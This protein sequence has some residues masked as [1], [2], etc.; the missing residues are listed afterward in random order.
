MDNTTRYKIN[1]LLDKD[2][3]KQYCQS[4]DD[5]PTELIV[6][7]DDVEHRCKVCIEYDNTKHDIWSWFVYYKDVITNEI[8]LESGSTT[9]DNA[10]GNMLNRISNA[11]PINEIKLIDGSHPRVIS[12]GCANNVCEY[13][14]IHRL[15]KVRPYK[16]CD[17][18]DFKGNAVKVLDLHCCPYCD[19]K[20]YSL[21]E[22]YCSSPESWRALAGREGNIYKCSDCGYTY[23]EITRMS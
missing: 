12:I 19:S 9:W 2:N 3:V 17:S 14:V 7:K 22:H 18:F 15:F 20:N 16:T 13:D 11:W 1:E 10:I 23:N 21:V 4:P 8:I 6:L 5:L